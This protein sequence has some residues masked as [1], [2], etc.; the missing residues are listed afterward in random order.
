MPPPDRE[1]EALR[2]AAGVSRPDDV[3]L[4]RVEGAGAFDLLDLAC[5]SRMHLRENEMLQTLLLHADGTV[6]ADAFVCQ[7]ESALFLLAEGP[8]PQELIRHLEE[9]RA[10]VAPSAQVELSDL[11]QDHVLLGVDGPFAWELVSTVLGPEV[12]GA[13]YLS[14]LRLGQVLCCRA[15]KTGEYGYQ[16]LVPRAEA[17][18]FEARLREAAGRQGALDV[19][20][21]AL[22]QCA[23]ENWHFAIRFI[24]G[25]PGKG[26]TPLELQLQWRVDSSKQFFGADAL[27]ARRERGLKARVTC[28]TAAE[29]IAQGDAVVLDGQR[30]GS[31]LT[32]GWSCIRKDWVGWALLD[33]GVAWPGIDALE[34]EAGA[35]RVRI[36]TRS[37]PLLN[38]RSLHVDPHRHSH[39]SRATDTFPP[40][41]VA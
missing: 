8:T 1:L 3:T 5:T 9:V 17:Q 25:A 38:N 19:G 12:L 15:G 22:D 33:L 34:V 28:F 6:F 39:Q 27:A 41:V 35:G 18:P 7:D 37:P 24:A 14:F 2:C 23:L 10:T 21:A 40:L 20:R 29:R 36:V 30:V 11:G 32:A 16:L 13:P 31:V 4:V 26:L